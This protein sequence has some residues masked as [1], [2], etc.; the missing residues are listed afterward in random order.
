MVI[1]IFTGSIAFAGGFYLGHSGITVDLDF[2]GE[3]PRA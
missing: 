2:G 3:N 1:I